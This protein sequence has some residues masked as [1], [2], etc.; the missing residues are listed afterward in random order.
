MAWTF[1]R[2][3]LES[4]RKAAKPPLMNRDS[5]ITETP[6]KCCLFFLDSE[7]ERRFAAI[8]RELSQ[9]KRMLYDLPEAVRQKV[10]FKPK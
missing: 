2:R 9:I 5:S 10:G 8:E 3:L 4:R 6:L 1:L 7:S